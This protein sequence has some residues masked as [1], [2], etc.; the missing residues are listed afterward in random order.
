MRFS[1][2]LE[3]EA[4]VSSYVMSHNFYQTV[5]SHNH[6][7]IIVLGTSCL[8]YWW[9]SMQSPPLNETSWFF[10]NRGTTF[11]CYKSYPMW[12]KHPSQFQLLHRLFL[13]EV[14]RCQSMYTVSDS[15]RNIS[16]RLMEET[17]RKC[18]S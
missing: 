16:G 3:Y 1:P 8:T 2:G 7:S 14:L 17:V 4:C 18:P 5:I 9:Y 12:K 11:W 15:P 13:K 10:S 6:A